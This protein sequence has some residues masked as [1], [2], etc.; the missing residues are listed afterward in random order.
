MLLRLA[1]WIGR[2]ACSHTCHCSHLFFGPGAPSLSSSGS[3]WLQKTAFLLSYC[4]VFRWPRLSLTGH[5][6]LSLPASQCQSSWQKSM[7]AD[8]VCTA[9]VPGKWVMERNQLWPGILQAELQ[10]C[11]RKLRRDFG[12][13]STC[14]ILCLLIHMQGPWWYPQFPVWFLGV[15]KDSGGY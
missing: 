12:D 2:R 11:F 9:Y 15:C 3:W 8:D 4:A 1:Y 7:E 5:A 14:C 6:L 13:L 10:F